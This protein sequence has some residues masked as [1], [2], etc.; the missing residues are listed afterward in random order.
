M[1]DQEVAD[2]ILEDSGM[3]NDV[4]EDHPCLTHAMENNG[5]ATFEKATFTDADDGEV[6]VRFVR[7]W[8][9]NLYRH[10]ESGKRVSSVDSISAIMCF[11]P[12]CGEQLE[13]PD[14]LMDY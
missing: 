1:T 6:G 9:V 4:V 7:H 2:R 10:T 12:F 3:L 14:K 5:C 11:C 13:D 8:V